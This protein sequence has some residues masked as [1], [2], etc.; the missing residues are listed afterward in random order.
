M[1]QGKFSVATYFETIVRIT[2]PKRGLT[3]YFDYRAH[4]TNLQ[5]PLGKHLID[6]RQ[7]VVLYY[8]YVR[9]PTQTHPHPRP[10]PPPLPLVSCLPCLLSAA[11]QQMRHADCW[12][13]VTPVDCHAALL[14]IS[15]NLDNKLINNIISNQVTK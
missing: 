8:R 10:Q 5:G 6:S 4:V 3:R 14:S 12:S 9:L 1:C 13:M 2:Y 7:Y 15:F 11:R